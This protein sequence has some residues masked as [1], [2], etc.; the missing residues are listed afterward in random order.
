MD[1][2]LT[3]KRKGHTQIIIK[4]VGV[5]VGVEVG[6]AKESNETPLQRQ[7]KVQLVHNTR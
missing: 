2:Q 5:A 3:I 7:E 6:V 4:P 1:F